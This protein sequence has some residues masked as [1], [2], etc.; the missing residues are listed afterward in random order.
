MASACEVGEC[1]GVHLNDVVRFL[2]SGNHDCDTLDYTIFRLDWVLN[3]LARY[4]DTE[5]TGAINARVIDL[6][7]EAREAVINADHSRGAFQA[8]CIFTGQPGRPKLTVPQEQ[9]QFL[10]ERRFNTTQIASLLGVSPRTIERRLRE[11]NLNI[12]TSYSNLSDQDLDS[13]LGNRARYGF[14]ELDMSTGLDLSIPS[15]RPLTFPGGQSENGY[16]AR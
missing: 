6:V 12:S 7:C 14:I 11:H 13:F 5:G 1:L 2:E 15:S 8:G 16:R 4:L 9:L 10:I 3:V